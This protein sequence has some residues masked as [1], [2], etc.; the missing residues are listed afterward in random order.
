MSQ[1]GGSHSCSLILLLLLLLLLLLAMLQLLQLLLLLLQ[2][3]C[4]LLRLRGLLR[5][6]VIHGLAWDVLVSDDLIA[7]NGGVDE[8]VAGPRHQL[9]LLGVRLGLSCGVGLLRLSLGLILCAKVMLLDLSLKVG[10]RS[11]LDLSCLSDC[12]GL[13]VGLIS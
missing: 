3:D 2:V 1:D 10:L 11:G 8:R 5:N 9:I 7:G 4:L 13:R 12:L 6:R